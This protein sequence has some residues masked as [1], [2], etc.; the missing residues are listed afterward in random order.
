MTRLA[1]ATAALGAPL[2][3]LDLAA[4]DANAADLARRAG[5]LPIRVASNAGTPSPASSP[6]RA[7]PA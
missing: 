2:A 6:C 1:D 4:F 3:A 7:S 5:G